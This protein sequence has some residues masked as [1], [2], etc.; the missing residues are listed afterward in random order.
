LTLFDRLGTEDKVM[1]ILPGK[2]ALV[3]FYHVI[4]YV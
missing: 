3:L 1:C 2:S 4:A